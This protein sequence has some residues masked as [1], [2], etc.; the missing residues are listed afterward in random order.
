M[1]LFLPRE[2]VPF[3]LV[4]AVKRVSNSVSFNDDFGLSFTSVL[5]PSDLCLV[6]TRYRKTGASA[7]ASAPGGSGP[8]HT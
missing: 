2:T 6:S 1:S 7:V 3:L 8:R 5:K 4:L